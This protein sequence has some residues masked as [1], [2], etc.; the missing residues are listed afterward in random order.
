MR[1][2]HVVCKAGT[3]R[4][5]GRLVAAASPDGY[6]AIFDANGVSSSRSSSSS[7]RRSRSPRDLRLPQISGDGLVD[8]EPPAR[9]RMATAW[10]E[11]MPTLEPMDLV[12][13]SK[14]I[15]RLQLVSSPTARPCA[16]RAPRRRRRACRSARWALK[17]I[18]VASGGA[19]AYRA[20]SPWVT[21]ALIPRRAGA[22]GGDRRRGDKRRTEPV[23]RGCGRV[24]AAL[25]TSFRT[26]SRPGDDDARRVRRPSMRRRCCCRAGGPPADA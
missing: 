13:S 7:S 1:R 18:C 12:L 8:V 20:A 16:A 2:R 3:E 9:L 21:A 26:R 24:G 17:R 14:S 25:C 6:A 4:L 19:R 23:G 11:P 22:R 15:S 10:L 5:A